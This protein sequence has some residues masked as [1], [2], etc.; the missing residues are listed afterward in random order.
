MTR[1]SHRCC[2]SIVSGLLFTLTATAASSLADQPS[3]RVQ[4]LLAQMSREE[5]MGIIRGAQE[6]NAVFQG[7]AGWTRGVPRLGIPDLRFADGPP[8]VLVRHE[9]T[10]MPSTLAMAAT[11]SRAEA[12]ANGALIGRDA[13][14]LGIDVILQPFINM[15]RDPTW[16]RAYNT[17]GEDPVLTGTLAAQFVVAAQAAGVMAQAKHFVAYDG[18]DDAVVDGQTLREVYME[19]FRAVVDA[20]VASIMCAYSKING[21]YSCGHEEAINQ[22][23]RGEDGFQGFV[24][25]DWGAAHGAEFIRRGMDMEQPGTGPSAFFVLGKEPDEPAMTK[26]EVTDL[27]NTMSAGVPEE[28]KFPLPEFTASDTPPLAGVSKNL[29]EAFERGTVSDADIDRA[30]GHVLTQ[31]ERFGW[32]DHPPRHS[33]QPQAIAENARVIQRTAERAAVLLK[34]EGVL[35]LKPSEPRSLA[36]IGPGALQTFAIV[37]GIEQSYGRAGREIGVWHALKSTTGGA[38]LK[39]AVA[40]DMTGV[41]IPADAITHLTRSDAASAPAVPDTHIDYTRR[42]GHAL[43]AGSNSRWSG[44]LT[45]PVTGDYDIN[46]QLLGATGKLA[47]DGHT[48]GQMA[49]WG[50]HGEIV[51]PNRDN[52]VPTTDGLDNVR[53]LV[54]LS[55]GEHAFT[56]EVKADVSGDAVQVR[57]AWVT[58]AMKEQDFAAAVAAARSSKVAVVFAWNRNRPHFGLPGDQDR[59]IAAVAAV[60]PNTIVVL[61]TGQAVAMPWLKDVRAVLEMWYTG[62]EGGW[63]AAN[64]LTGKTSPAGR[65]P[66]TWPRRLED[67]LAND[68]AHPERSSTGIGGKTQYAEGVNLGYRWFDR[69]GVEPLFPF[70]FGLSYTRF[71]YSQLSVRHSADGGLDVECTIRNSGKRTADEVVQAYLGAPEDPPAGAAFAVHALADFARITL[72]PGATQRLHMHVAPERLRYWSNANSAWHAVPGARTV[73]VGASSRDL[74]LSQ[75]VSGQ[76]PG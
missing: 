37:N 29:G 43:P 61:N 67:S 50:G 74:R 20:G 21:T 6:P 71:A 34:N 44:T 1:A 33:I 69:E 56:V 63:A 9:S 41:A 54:T 11:F 58:P 5:K 75:R 59:L 39:L 36:L 42:S 8:G 15:Y 62:D 7:E 31:M 28:Q 23:L 25:S 18:G 30:A 46:L 10:G 76:H 57:L 13:R 12:A 51:F 19:P 17:L 4:S 55:A 26:E 38:G 60:N 40:D 27:V 32:L 24:T 49:W 16:D 70:G 2:S 14:A 64:L 73:Y 35:P 22:I 45:A 3:P 47:I 53:R 68:P 72:R 65:L 52:V 48:V 66:I